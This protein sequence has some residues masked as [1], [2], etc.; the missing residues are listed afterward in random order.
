VAHPRLI[1]ADRPV[2]FLSFGSP[3]SYLAAERVNAT[4]PVVPVWQPVLEPASAAPGG[5]ASASDPAE[6][7]A[8]ERL[9]AERGLPPVRWP[10][11]NEPAAEPSPALLAA[12]YAQGAGRAV[13]FSLA[14]LRQ[15]FAAGRNLSD[16][17]TVLLAAAA[18]ELH[19]RAVLKGIESRAVKERLEAANR[20]AREL[21]VERLPAVTAG[22]TVFYGDQALEE[23][24]AA[25][26]RA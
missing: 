19:P 12:I 22:G 6:R 14:A 25:I 11:S 15:A 10:P 17:D 8:V 21:G 2:F 23:A 26:G 20:M 5:G 24:A 3:W 9:A 13:A 1:E 16:V 18:C 7:H 4:L